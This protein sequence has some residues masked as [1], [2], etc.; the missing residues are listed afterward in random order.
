MATTG[1]LI[2][3]QPLLQ[4]VAHSHAGVYV[5]DMARSIAFYREMLGFDVRYDSAP[6]HPGD[7]VV[8]GLVAGLAVELVKK[9]E[10]GVIA[11]PVSADGMGI[12]NLSFSIPDVDAAHTA[13]LAHGL[14]DVG[15]PATLPSGVRLMLF[16]DPDGNL[17]ELL[18]LL[19]HR[20]V[21]EMLT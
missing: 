11:A 12:A 13:L 19:G 4:P 10:L 6:G 21:F 1:V 5:S 8:I 14:S 18:D 16:R 15:A 7:R 20:S 17:I 2:R 3:K 9:T